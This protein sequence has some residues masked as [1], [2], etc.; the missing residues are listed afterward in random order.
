LTLEEAQAPVL[1]TRILLGTLSSLLQQDFKRLAT[2]L[3]CAT[4]ERESGWMALSHCQSDGLLE[5][6][7]GTPG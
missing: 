3:T 7:Y 2:M 6:K 4:P 5:L 1:S